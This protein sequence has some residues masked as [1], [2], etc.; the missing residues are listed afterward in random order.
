MKK[1]IQAIFILIGFQALVACEHDGGIGAV[2]EQINAVDFVHEQMPRTTDEAIPV[3]L[4]NMDIS[5]TE[6][7]ETFDFMFNE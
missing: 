4:T 2:D 1:T 6:D 5:F 3:G 7:T